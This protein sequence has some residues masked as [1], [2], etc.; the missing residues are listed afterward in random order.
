MTYEVAD[1]PDTSNF[2]I[3]IF[4][5]I[6]LPNGDQTIAERGQGPEF[7][8]VLVQDEDGDLIDEKEDLATYEEAQTAA[9]EFQAKYPGAEVNDSP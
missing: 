2:E 7:Y 4:A 9:A 8:D 6:T 5:M 1:K 3:T